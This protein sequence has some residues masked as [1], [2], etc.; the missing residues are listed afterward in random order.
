M[1]SASLDSFDSALS[2]GLGVFGDLGIFGATA[3]LM[4]AGVVFG[5]LRRRSTPEASAALAGFAIALVLGFIL[6]W[7]EQPAFAVFLATLAASH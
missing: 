7:W 3:Y 6:D 1:G 4:L 2:S 5:E